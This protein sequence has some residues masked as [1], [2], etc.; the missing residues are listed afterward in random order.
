MKIQLMIQSL[1]KIQFRVCHFFTN[2]IFDSPKF[3]FLI[4]ILVENK[5]QLNYLI[6]LK[7][8]NYHHN[9]YFT[10]NSFAIQVLRTKRFLAFV[11][12]S[13]FYQKLLC[14]TKNI[15]F[16]NKGEIVTILIL[17]ETPLQFQIFKSTDCQD[18]CHNPYFTGNS[19]AI[20]NK[21]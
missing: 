1:S 2:S 9:P 14:N 18:C 21:G 7:Q 15:Q 4:I 20:Q 3:K 5:L 12:Q 6:T 19:F 13:L 17:L 16:N 10:G 11:S 8:L